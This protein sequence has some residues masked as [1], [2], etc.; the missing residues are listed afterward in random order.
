M[1]TPIS[2]KISVVE[3]RACRMV[4]ALVGATQVGVWDGGGWCSKMGG[5]GTGRKAASQ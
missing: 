1:L 3:A 4:T 2:L 5:R